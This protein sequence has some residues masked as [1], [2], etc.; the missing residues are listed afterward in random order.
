VKP[1]KGEV[2]REEVRSWRGN[3]LEG[4]IGIPQPAAMM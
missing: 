4:D 2:H 1:L 3:A